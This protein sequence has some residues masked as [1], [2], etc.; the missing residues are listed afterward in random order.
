[1]R[2]GCKGEAEPQKRASEGAGRRPWPARFSERHSAQFVMFLY[3]FRL[4]TLTTGFSLALAHEMLDCCA[5]NVTGEKLDVQR[6][7]SMSGSGK[8]LETRFIEATTSK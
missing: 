5:V 8:L 2:A 6:G 7:H 3:S 1:M 4:L